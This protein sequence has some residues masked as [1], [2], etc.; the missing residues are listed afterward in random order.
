MMK[1]LNIAQVITRCRRQKGVTQEELAFYMGVSKASV[2]KWETGQSYPDITFL[3]Q[4]AA[5]F[6][7]TLDELLGY[8][9][10]ME[11]ADI[12]KTYEYFC[13][14]FAR[15][16]FEEVYG[17][18]QEMVKKYY[19]CFQFVFLTAYLYLNHHMMAGTPGR[20]SEVVEEAGKLFYRVKTE[21]QEAGLAKEAE[22]GEATTLLLLNRPAEVLELLGEKI[23]PLMQ[24][25]DLIA[26]A[27][28]MLGNQ[29]AAV[30]TREIMLYQ[31]LMGM[32]GQIPQLVIAQA[33]SPDK[34]ELL[35][36]KANQLESIFE[37]EKLNPNS[38]ALIYLAAAQFYMGIEN[39]EKTIEYLNRYVD[40]VD[41]FFPLKLH[42]DHFFENLDEWIKELELGSAA[43]RDE[44]LV[45][46][47]IYQAL[48]EN[49]PFAGMKEKTEFKA[50]VN[51]LRF[52]LGMEEKSDE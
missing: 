2:S 35:L 4:L 3:P 26:Q 46:E 7:I 30:Q 17:E 20:C 15:R 10:Q 39:Q 48:A 43:P 38:M 18:C 9:P 36:N 29:K 40:M 23:R 31:H 21:C 13:R 41:Y 34:V 8:E 22:H 49:P 47:S 44:K 6:N 27:Y 32:L 45:K 25:A 1:E 24:D 28:L 5:Y 37:A 42:G 11:L 33:A 19:S 52:K 51:R 50:L 14:E 16:P 12:R